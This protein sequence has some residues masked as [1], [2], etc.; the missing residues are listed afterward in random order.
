MEP[1]VRR[2]AL[3]RPT[4]RLSRS[5]ASLLAVSGL[6]AASCT[7]EPI[8]PDETSTTTVVVLPTESSDGADESVSA[9]IAPLLIAALAAD[10]IPEDVAVCLVDGVLESDDLPAA[11]RDAFIAGVAGDEPPTDAIAEIFADGTLECGMLEF[12]AE[13]AGSELTAALGISEDEA[14]CLTEGLWAS[15]AMQRI[16]VE[17]VKA[18]FAEKPAPSVDPATL[19]LIVSNYVDLMASCGVNDHMARA[20]EGEI[21]ISSDTASCFVAESNASE[22]MRPII[23]QTLLQSLASPTTDVD[24]LLEMSDSVQAENEDALQTATI[25]ALLLCATDAELEAIGLNTP[26]GLP[27]EVAGYQLWASDLTRELNTLSE[28]YGDRNWV[29]G[30][31]GDDELRYRLVVS[32][33]DGPSVDES[34]PATLREWIP[35]EGLFAIEGGFDMESRPATSRTVDGGTRLTCSPGFVGD[36]SEIEIAR[37]IFNDVGWDEAITLDWVSAMCFFTNATH[38]G[39][40]KSDAR[41]SIDELAVIAGQIALELAN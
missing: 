34:D 7:S 23:A 11:V 10:G 6:L 40:I 20:A 4:S 21:G 18:E 2:F 1:R 12:A 35:A 33:T 25:D 32:V 14:R 16:Y 24:A 37:D 3:G 41:D 31:Y 29:F 5:I 28:G 9:E 13:A 8:V 15:E 38:V 30:V 22:A 27:P 39:F 36:D 17:I 26:A 19:D